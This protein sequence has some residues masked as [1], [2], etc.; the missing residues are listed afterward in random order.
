MAISNSTDLND[1][2]GQI[3]AK[4]AISAAYAARV[5]RNIVSVYEV[6]L[7]AG[8]IVV[9][10]FSGLTEGALTEGTA[11]TSTTWGS[12]GVTLTP[13][14][15]GIYV[16]ISKRV[17][18]ADPFADLSPYGE[19]LG[20]ALAVGEDTAILAI[21][22]SGAFNSSVG[23]LGVDISGN[24]FRQGIAALEA[25][26]APKPYFAVLAP[27]SWAK[28]I[29][30][31][32]NA[33]VF[34]GVG[35]GIVNGFGEGMPSLNGYVGAPYGIPTFISTCVPVGGT[36]N[37]YNVMFSKQA[38]AYGYMKDIGVD[39]FDNVTA[40]AFDIMAWRSAHQAIITKEYGVTMYDKY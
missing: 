30:E 2:V 13:V 39:V 16:Q 25:A 17:L 33:S 12:D 4:D 31:F 34:D 6:P 15:R 27:Q 36:A 9:P 18:H 22:G 7:G 32:G 26:N 14:E 21:M 10:R 19:Q 28:M 3:V 37:R 38:V 23:T 8:S 5:M 20:R 29:N 11:T 1:L 40:R 35:A 24:V